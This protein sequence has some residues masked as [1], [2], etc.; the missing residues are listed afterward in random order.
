M[1]L[2]CGYLI[3]VGNSFLWCVWKGYAFSACSESSSQ[4]LLPKREVRQENPTGRSNKMAY[5]GLAKPFCPNRLSFFPDTKFL[6]SGGQLPSTRSHVAWRFTKWLIS[7]S[8]STSL[9]LSTLCPWQLLDSLGRAPP[10]SGLSLI[11]SVSQLVHAPQVTPKEYSLGKTM[12]RFHLAEGICIWWWKKGNI[13]D[14]HRIE[15][16]SHYLTWNSWLKNGSNTGHMVIVVFDSS[17]Q[18]Q[19][20]SEWRNEKTSRGHLRINSPVY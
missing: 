16:V 17:F 7:P 19:Q 6:T 9:L 20:Q 18:R 5:L 10:S 14:S 13:A 4:K 3:S 15:T 8:E 1:L 2:T 12:K 11:P